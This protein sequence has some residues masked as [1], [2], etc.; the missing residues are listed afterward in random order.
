V[1]SKF[2]IHDLSRLKAIKA[3]EYF[4]LNMPLELGIDL[5]CKRFKRGRW[6]KKR[7]L[8]LEAKPFR[9]KAAISDL[10]NSDIAVHGNQP[11]KVVKAVRDWLNATAD[12]HAPGPNEIWNRF[13]AFMADNFL[14]LKA[15]GFSN[16]DIKQ[17]PIDE[18]IA[19]MKSWLRTNK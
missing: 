6:S 15:R 13:N 17:L 16:H 8:I 18:L 12:L 11:V 2:G 10:S 3:G 9:Y 5:G 4:R 7:C 19:C 1:A 14:L